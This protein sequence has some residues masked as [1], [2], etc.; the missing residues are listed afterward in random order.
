MEEMF[1]VGM[2]FDWFSGDTS[3]YGY[4]RM[5]VWIGE[6]GRE[7]SGMIGFRSLVKVLRAKCL[8]AFFM[9]QDDCRSLKHFEVEDKW[10][11]A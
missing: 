3:I 8:R 2:I 6:T 11:R 4:M 10:L 1:E 9:M 5:G 7:G